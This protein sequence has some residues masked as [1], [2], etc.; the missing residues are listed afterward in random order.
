MKTSTS[1]VSR[2]ASLAIALAAHV[3][4]G[5]APVAAAENPMIASFMFR[6]APIEYAMS[7]LGE[8]WGRHIVVNQSAKDV[9]VRTFL[10]DIDCEAALKAVCQGHGLWYREDPQSGVIFVQSVEEFTQSSVFSEKKFVEVVTLAYPRAEDIAA[11][12]Q[13]AY[14]DTVVYT[15]PDEDNDDE[16]GDIS[17]ALDR[18]D[19]L[20][21]R[22]SI[23]EGN[24]SS[25]QSYS[26]SGRGRTNS[27]RNNETTRGMENIRRF[28]D[29]RERAGK[30]IEYMTR[31]PGTTNVQ[32]GAPTDQTAATSAEEAPKVVTLGVVFLSII[33]RSN[34]IV[35]RSSDRDML[36]QMRETIRQLDVPK[37]QVLLEVRVLRLDITDEKDRDISF[38]AAESGHSDA[39]FEGGFSQQM[40]VIEETG[41]LNL[42]NLAGLSGH[43]VFQI[44]SDHYKVRLNLLDGKGKVRT[45]ATPTLLVADYEASRVFIGK[46][47]SVV[48]D[49][50]EQQS[51]SSGDNPVVITTVN[52]TIQRR[53]VGMSLVIT[54]KI[55]ADGTVTLRV[56]QERAEADENN[57]KTVTYGSG[58]QER[59]FKTIPVHKQIITS[60]VV[61]K[62]GETIAL[63][64]LMQHEESDTI[65]K[66]PLV[67]DIPYLG[68]LFRYVSHDATDS[69]LLVMIK[70]TVIRAP[71]GAKSA[72]DDYVRANLQD[73]RNLHEAT[74]KAAERRT[75][76]AKAFLEE[77][78]PS[79][80]ENLF[81]KEMDFEWVPQQRRR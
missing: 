60:S 65:Q 47:M 39:I 62:D 1:H 81:N 25:Q 9:T 57:E 40:N 15:A 29:D 27:R 36:A 37:A 38:L 13:E 67:G 31:Q 22:S 49:V 2:F 4:A 74:G 3:A 54:P 46:E 66:I 33:R 44:M 12:I 73:R 34:S 16:I 80:D 59:S 5:A 24:A 61:A 72:T 35:M 30:Y 52:P 50:E 55:H 28:T 79:D 8:T 69:E 7:M 23:L 63:G 10:K 41:R 19:Q 17:R 78:E 6:D 75:E 45:I 77:I 11:A 70:P 18:M 14:R 20:Q 32:I 68:A 21:D 56:M 71:A 43:P 51:V 53:D 42:G 76:R 58:S 64:G 26:S 48:T